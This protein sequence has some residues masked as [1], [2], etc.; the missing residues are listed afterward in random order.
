MDRLRRCKLCSVWSRSGGSERVPGWVRPPSLFR[1]RME[2]SVYKARCSL[3]GLSWLTGPGELL[4]R[5]T[6]G[7]SVAGS[8]AGFHQVEALSTGP[9]AEGFYSVG[10]NCLS[11]Y[12]DGGVLGGRNEEGLD[13]PLDTWL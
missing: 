12:C 3:W 8:L 7:G 9:L 1:S 2:W 13:N 10:T 5:K 6:R 11:G 4:G